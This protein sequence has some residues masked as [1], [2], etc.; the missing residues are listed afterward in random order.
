MKKD[1]GIL[2]LITGLL[3]LMFV[4][5]KLCSVIDW[6]W[7]WVTLPFWWRAPIYLIAI[8]IGFLIMFFKYVFK[9]G[10]AKTL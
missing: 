9:K 10:K 7:W 2:K 8:L 3:G 4:G 6:S 1:N 5:L